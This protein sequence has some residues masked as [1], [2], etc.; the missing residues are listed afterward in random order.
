[1]NTFSN[2]GPKNGN[3]ELKK[4][5]YKLLIDANLQKIMN[6]GKLGFFMFSTDKDISEYF[7]KN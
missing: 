3:I 5:I 1:M 4:K 6:K 7:L 2:F